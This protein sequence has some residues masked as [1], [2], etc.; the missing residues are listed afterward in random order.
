MRDLQ[1]SCVGLCCV[2]GLV[3]GASVA[4]ASDYYKV[5][6]TRKSDN[7][8]EVVGRGIYVITRFCYEYVYY[9]DAILKIDSQVGYTIG[10]I[11]F[12]QSGG[13]KCDIEKIVK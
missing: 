7:L 5:E 12:V 2:A 6:V 3:F 10:E 1:S 11:V 4:A 8:Y 13:A 9:E